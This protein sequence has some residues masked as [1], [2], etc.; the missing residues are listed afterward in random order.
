LL[1]AALAGGDDREHRE[2]RQR[3]RAGSA[4]PWNDDAHVEIV[5]VATA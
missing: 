5:A 4:D 3:A 1:A 2:Q